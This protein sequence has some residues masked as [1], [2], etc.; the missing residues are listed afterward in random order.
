MGRGSE[1]EAVGLDYDLPV[2]PLTSQ[3]TDRE[4]IQREWPNPQDLLFA[5]LK[6]PAFLFQILRPKE[7][8]ILNR[9]CCRPLTQRTAHGKK[10]HN[11][12]AMPREGTEMQTERMEMYVPLIKSALSMALG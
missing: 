4:T 10:T 7:T 11:T 3:E 5:G 6:S 9:E 2:P 12:V 8:H 1:T